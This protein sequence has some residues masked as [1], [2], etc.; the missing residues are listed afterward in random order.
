LLVEA[1]ANFVI[2][3]HNLIPFKIDEKMFV[4]LESQ[5]KLVAFGVEAV[6]GQTQVVLKPLGEGIPQSP[7]VAGAAILGNGQVALVLD[8]SGLVEEGQSAA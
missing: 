2:C 4:F 6:L 3:F 1:F 5:R 8:P 7:D